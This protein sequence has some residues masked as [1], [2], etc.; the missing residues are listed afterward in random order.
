M[1]SPE[2]VT[3][4]LLAAAAVGLFLVKGALEVAYHCNC[5]GAR[6]RNG[7]SEEEA[8]A[9]AEGEKEGCPRPSHQ[10]R[11]EGVH[12]QGHGKVQ[13]ATGS[14]LRC[15]HEKSHEEKS[16][17]RVKKARTAE[18]GRRSGISHETPTSG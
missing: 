8:E 14:L 2:T 17:I 3:T 5:C 1:V 13:E 12:H 4:I 10:N 18:G 11:E 15:W 7:T 6:A 16:P 9:E